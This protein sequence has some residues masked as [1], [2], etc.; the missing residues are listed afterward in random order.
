[1]PTVGT[2]ELVKMAQ[3]AV[4]KRS[5]SSCLTFILI[6]AYLR[7]SRISPISQLNRGS[8]HSF[9][10]STFSIMSS[11]VNNQIKSSYLYSDRGGP[12][13]TRLVSVE[14]MRNSCNQEC[15]VFADEL[16]IETKQQHFALHCEVK[17]PMP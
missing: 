16:I 8:D 15:S 1:M 12:F 11:D 9:R 5:M 7:Q 14:A 10:G 6:K 4:K 17:I 3:N 2:N 13:S